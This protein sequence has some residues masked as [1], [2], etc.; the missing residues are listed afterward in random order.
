M[1]SSVVLWLIISL[2]E[3]EHFRVN[4]LNGKYGW[5]IGQ[6]LVMRA[7]GRIMTGIILV[8]FQ[9]RYSPTVTVEFIKSG[10]MEV[11]QITLGFS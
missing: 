9:L 4:W 10:C 1:G 8:D 3:L 7:V 5:L 2:K 11:I 6:G